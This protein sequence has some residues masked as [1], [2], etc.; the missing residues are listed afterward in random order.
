ML[1]DVAARIES[2]GKLFELSLADAVVP[3]NE[4]ASEFGIEASLDAP[5]A[6]AWLSVA[7]ILFPAAGYALFNVYRDK[8]MMYLSSHQ[9]MKC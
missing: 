7:V 3:L 4:K 9:E 1:A 5:A 8:V 6:P 2:P